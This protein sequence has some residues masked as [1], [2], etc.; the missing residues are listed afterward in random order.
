[1]RPTNA[2]TPTGAGSD[3]WRRRGRLREVMREHGRLAGHVR[4]LTP[5]CCHRAAD[6]TGRIG[7]LLGLALLLLGG[8]ARLFILLARDLARA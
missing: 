8:G 6:L 7:F 5:G 1:M 3:A 4:N 2:T